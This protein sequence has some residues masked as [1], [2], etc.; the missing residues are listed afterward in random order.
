MTFC[1]EAHLGRDLKD[2]VLCGHSGWEAFT[3]PPAREKG[4]AVRAV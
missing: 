2:T 1:E 3:G 4:H